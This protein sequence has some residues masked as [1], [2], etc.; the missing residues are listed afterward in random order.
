MARYV[1]NVESVVVKRGVC[2]MPSGFICPFPISV[3]CTVLECGLNRD[4]I[5][6][7]L[8]MHF[9]ARSRLVSSHPWTD[10]RLE[11]KWSFLLES[12]TLW[13]VNVLKISV[14]CTVNQCQ[15]R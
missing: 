4:G 15:K 10:Q 6:S 2:Y 8:V 12:S 5:R 9:G 1:N 13:E 7:L 14:I 11:G 3:Y